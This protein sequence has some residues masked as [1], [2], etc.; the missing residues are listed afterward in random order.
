VKLGALLLAAALLFAGCAGG[1]EGAGSTVTVTSTIPSAEMMEVRVYFLREGKVWP[2]LRQVAETEAVASAALTELQGGPTEMETSDLGFTS[3][4]AAD[5]QGVTIS[6]GV[7]DV[8]GLID[9]TNGG[10]AQIVYTLT[11]FPTV[12]GHRRPDRGPELRDRDLGNGDAGDV[13]LHDR[14]L[15]GPV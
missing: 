15:H 5:F 13:R 2:V 11:Q 10:L 12:D 3:A 7:A 14:G 6:D 1:D 9:H 8:D 4:V